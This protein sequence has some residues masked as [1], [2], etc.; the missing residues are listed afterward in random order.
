MVDYFFNDLDL[1]MEIIGLWR[2]NVS[3]VN[4]LESE[5]MFMCLFMVSC[6]SFVCN[7]RSLLVDCVRRLILGIGGV[8]VI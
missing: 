5:F 2:Y 6:C 8:L 7:G 4:V 1:I 3:V